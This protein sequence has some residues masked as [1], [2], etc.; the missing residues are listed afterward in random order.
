MTCL[1]VGGRSFYFLPELLDVQKFSA[2]FFNKFTS[3]KSYI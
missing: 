1:G 2:L 3:Y